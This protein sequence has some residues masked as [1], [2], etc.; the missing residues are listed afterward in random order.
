M[1]DKYLK[2]PD[3]A[4]TRRAN[5][6]LR[7]VLGEMA[8]LDLYASRVVEEWKTANGKPMLSPS[9]CGDLVDRIVE[10]MLW[11]QSEIER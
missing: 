9:A 5:A 6:E 2:R 7:A 8:D 3:K 11:A 1:P 4:N 10:A